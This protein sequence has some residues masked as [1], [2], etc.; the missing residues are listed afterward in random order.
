[1][2]RCGRQ[3]G[4]PCAGNRR[5]FHACLEDTV[6]RLWDFSSWRNSPQTVIRRGEDMGKILS[7]EIA[8]SAGKA[9]AM[10]CNCLRKIAKNRPNAFHHQGYRACAGQSADGPASRCHSPGKWGC[11]EKSRKRFFTRRRSVFLQTGGATDFV[12]PGES[13][14][15]RTREVCVM[16]AGVPHIETPIDLKTPYG[17]LVCMQARDGLLVHRAEASEHRKSSR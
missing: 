12:C 14:R 15:L 1:M 7:S 4:P 13:F 17:I 8:F 11:F 9:M 6:R 5:W 2:W 3:H 16:P 10:S